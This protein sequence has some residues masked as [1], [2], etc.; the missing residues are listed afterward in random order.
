MTAKEE[1]MHRIE[2]IDEIRTI[3]DDIRRNEMAELDEIV[4][5]KPA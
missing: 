2:R 1:V 5:A 4:D 3:L